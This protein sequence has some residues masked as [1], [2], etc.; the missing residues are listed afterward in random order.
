METVSYSFCQQFK[1]SAQLVTFAAAKCHRFDTVS[2]RLTRFALDQIANL[3]V[4]TVY[5]ADRQLEA[6]MR[7]EI[8]FPHA[9]RLNAFNQCYYFVGLINKYRINRIKHKKHMN[10]ITR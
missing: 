4:G 3:R 1:T 10:G 8:H 2:P 7:V 9:P 6:S 5:G